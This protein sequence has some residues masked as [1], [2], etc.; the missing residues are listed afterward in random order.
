MTVTSFPLATG[1]EASY[2]DAE[3][4]RI[5]AAYTGASGGVATYSGMRPSG[6]LTDGLITANGTPNNTVFCSA[7]VLHHRSGSGGGSGEYVTINDASATLTVAAPDATLLRKDAVFVD[8]DAV[9]AVDRIIYV[10]G[11]PG[12]G[13]FPA[14]NPGPNV[15]RYRLANVDCRSL[16]VVGGSTAVIRP[17]DIFPTLTYTAAMGG[18]ILCL[19]SA[20]PVTPHVG[21]EIWEIDT[22]RLLT[23]DGTVWGASGRIQFVTSAARPATPTNGQQIFETDTG[24]VRMWRSDQSIWNAIGGDKPYGRRERNSNQ[25][26][27]NNAWTTISWDLTVTDDPGGTFSFVDG[28]NPTRF[29]LPIIG[30]WK[31]WFGAQW[32]AIGTN[33]G[34]R[35]LQVRKNAA[36]NVGSGTGMVPEVNRRPNTSSG[37][38]DLR[39]AAIIKTTATTD[40]IEVFAYHLDSASNNLNLQAG[41]NTFLE[42]EFMRD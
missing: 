30:T 9:A 14:L 3:L 13:S 6:S 15:N 34:I 40:Y 23:W 29:K 27:N 28:A 22:G 37:V 36:G 18:R 21:L 42:A 5:F 1:L 8:P 10:V 19:S 25:L 20:R 41:G 7:F 11:T 39:A 26:A 16:A 38:S 31:I 4:R 12:S 17:A 2:D 24:L 33:D 32:S 35:V